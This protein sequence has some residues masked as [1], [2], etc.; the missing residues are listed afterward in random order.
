MSVPRLWSWRLS[1]FAAKVRV[2]F[3]EKGVELELLEIDPRER[4]KRLRELNPTNRVPVLEVDGVAVRESTAI[5]EWLEDT[6]PDSPLWPADAGA[7][8]A[9]RGLLRFV[10]DELTVNF[11]LSMRKEAFGLDDSDHPEIVSIL[12]ER[13]VRRWST[14]EELLERSD[15]PWMAASEEPSLVDLAAIP[16]AVRLPAWKP[17]LQPSEQEHPQTAAWLGRLRERPSAAEVDRRGQPVA[18]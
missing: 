9:A 7:R 15:G 16:M 4:P 3:A 18:D 2:A 13:L 12:R 6:H 14:V 11:F 5:C 1:P 10:D 8:A 17:E